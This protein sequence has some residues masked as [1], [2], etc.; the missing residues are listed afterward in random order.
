MMLKLTDADDTSTTV[1]Y[2]G[3]QVLRNGGPQATT[4]QQVTIP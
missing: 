1:V 4:S 2:N 3:H